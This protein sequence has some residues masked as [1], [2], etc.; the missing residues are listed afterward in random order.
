MTQES[1]TTG[2]IAIRDT[3][4]QLYAIPEQEM[5]R[6]KVPEDKEGEFALEPVEGGTQEDEVSGYY[7]QRWDWNAFFRGNW[8]GVVASDGASFRGW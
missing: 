1:G 8:A 6:Y 3:S 5:E 2:V 7:Q 4:G